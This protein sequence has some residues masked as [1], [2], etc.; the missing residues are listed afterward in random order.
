[1]R[2]ALRKVGVL[3]RRIAEAG[4]TRS[5]GDDS[6]DRDGLAGRGRSTRRS[7]RDDDA[8]H[9]GAASSTTSRAG[10]TAMRCAMDRAL[11]PGL[12]K[13]S[14][15]QDAGPVRTRSTL[16]TKDEM[17]EGDRARRRA[18]GGTSPIA[19]SASTSPRCP[20]DIAS[21]SRPFG[22]LRRISSSSP[23][24]PTAGGSPERCGA[25]RL[26]MV[27]APTETRRSPRSAPGVGRV[28]GHEQIARPLP[29]RDGLR[30]A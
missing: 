25:G 8:A 30:R 27:H 23:G 17:V 4:P 10:S 29:R 15:G 21:V 2:S 22:R 28:R 9:P 18:A 6:G 7:V 5:G 11:H 19:R 13:H 12:A 14:L 20:G 1:M 26:A 3:L 16:T 24:R